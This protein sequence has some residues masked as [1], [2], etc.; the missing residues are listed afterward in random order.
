MGEIVNLSEFFAKDQCYCLNQNP[1]HTFS[2]LFVGD[3]TLFL[4]S[5]VDGEI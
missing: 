4:Q 2:N 5:D 3:E 1:D